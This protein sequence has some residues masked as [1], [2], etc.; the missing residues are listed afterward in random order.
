MAEYRGDVGRERG[1]PLLGV[2]DVA[3]A[4][5]VRGGV[6]VTALVEG[7]RLGCDQGGGRLLR[8]ALLD[9]VLFRQQLL[10]AFTGHRTRR[11]KRHGVEGTYAKL[12][13]LA[14]PAL[15][16][17]EQPI[18]VDRTIG[19]RGHPQIQPAA[20]GMHAG[21]VLAG[22]GGSVGILLANLGGLNLAI[23][24]SVDGGS[25]HL[26]LPSTLAPRAPSP[27]TST[28]Y[29]RFI[30]KGSEDLRIKEYATYRLVPKAFMKAG[31]DFGRRM[32]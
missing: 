27:P 19:P 30:A 25:R 24:Q 7:H 4:G 2:L 28:P 9:R 5:A 8:L 13:V 16:V 11:S 26:R 14:G 6:G 15:L 18:A 3:P 10:T 22:L 29:L 12:L 23:R 21:L 31:V 20:V 17:A 1:G 32:N